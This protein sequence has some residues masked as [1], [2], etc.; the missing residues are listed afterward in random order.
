MRTLI[1]YLAGIATAYTALAIWHR[2]PGLTE[3]PDWTPAEREIREAN[4]REFERH[5]D[6]GY[7][8]GA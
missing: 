7:G 6:R 2:L 1:A 4:R 3:D 8:A 5:L